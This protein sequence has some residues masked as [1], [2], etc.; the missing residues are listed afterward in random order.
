M[1]VPLPYVLSKCTQGVV[2]GAV[3]SLLGPDY[4][5]WA[6]LVNRDDFQP[7]ITWAQL[8]GLARFAEMTFSPVLTQMIIARVI[9][10]T[11]FW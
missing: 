5:S 3:V 10:I 9:L 6:G 4:M 2:G 8:A 1:W 7:G 11:F